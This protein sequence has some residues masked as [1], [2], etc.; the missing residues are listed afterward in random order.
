[1]RRLVVKYRFA[2]FEIDLNRHELRQSGE[3]IH[4]EPQVFD[5]IVHFVRN[6]DRIVSKDELIET[7]WHGRIISEAALSSRINGAR[8]ALGD[9]GND[10]IFI[11]TLHKRGFRFVADVKVVS[12][13]E[14]DIDVARLVPD[15]GAALTDVPVSVSVSAEVSCLDDV[16]SESVKAE[17]VTRPSIAVMPFANL[18]D[19]PEN[20]YFSYGMT[21]D[22]IRLLARNRWLAVMSRHSTSAFQGR[23]VNVRDVSEQLGVK[24]VLV[25]SIRKNRDAVRISAE[26]VRAADGKQ[27]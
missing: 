15:G 11:K 18:S 25:G 2:H 21:E 9:N 20:D 4:I 10:Q 27:L 6:R 19:N 26:L 12:T 1:M 8:R 13:A 24:Y 3:V 23:A 14:A 22:I 7:I 5:L 17:A 16:V